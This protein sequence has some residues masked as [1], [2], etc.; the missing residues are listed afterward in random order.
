V[1]LDSLIDTSAKMPYHRLL[2]DC[3]N[4]DQS[5]TEKQ[6]REHDRC[7][8]TAKPACLELLPRDRLHAFQMQ[9]TG[10]IFGRRR[11][12]ALRAEKPIHERALY[13]FYKYTRIW[14]PS[15][16]VGGYFSQKGRWVP[17]ASSF[18]R[19][20]FLSSAGLISTNFQ[21]NR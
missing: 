17:Q 16:I 19:N 12:V 9:E 6:K 14:R 5:R 11:K 4:R 21:S 3:P 7:N 8:C 2:P 18:R 13:Q 20:Y 10:I 1:L 15:T